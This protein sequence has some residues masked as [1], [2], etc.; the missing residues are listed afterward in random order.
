MLFRSGVEPTAGNLIVNAFGIIE[1]KPAKE[2]EQP[3]APATRR[4]DL[5]YL[6]AIPFEVVRR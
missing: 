6:P 1:A 2:G 3:A 4:T 5:G